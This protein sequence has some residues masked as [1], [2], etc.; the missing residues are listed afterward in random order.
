M[1]A[2]FR[3][4]KVITALLMLQ[5]ALLSHQHHCI[6]VFVNAVWTGT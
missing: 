3:R 6:I 4:F 5:T 1:V 2:V